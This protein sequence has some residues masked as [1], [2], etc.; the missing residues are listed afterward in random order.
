MVAKRKRDTSV[1]SRSKK[2]EESSPPPAD[3]AQ[4]IFRKYFEAQFE[5]IE[6]APVKASEVL[7]SEED[8][9][10]YNSEEDDDNSDSEDGWDGLSGEEDDEPKVE[11]VEH[12]DA[13][14]DGD[15]LM[16]KQARKAFLVRTLF[17]FNFQD[18]KLTYNLPERYA[19][20]GCPNKTNVEIEYRKRQGRRRCRRR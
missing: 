18:Y 10:D 5:P 20:F 12:K 4:D 9:E 13:A 11:V 1:V 2:T 15:D 3:N 8:D 17:L 16:H 6:A 19:L 7:E 14:T